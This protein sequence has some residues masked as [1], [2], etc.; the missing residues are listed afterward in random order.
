M[1]TKTYTTIDRKAQ[2][3]PSGEW[4]G[5]PDKVQWQDEATG[6]PCL[7]VRHPTSGH[8][9]GYA[10]VSPDHPLYGKGYDDV[11]FDVHGGITFT[12]PCQPG[13]D[14]SKGVC[15]LPD[16]GEPDHVWWFGFDCAH[17]GDYSP[18]DKRYEE[19][20]GYPF[21]VQ[22]YENYRTLEYVKQECANLAAQLAESRETVH[23]KAADRCAIGHQDSHE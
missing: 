15:H 1:Q 10:G 18:K 17:A 8:W 13:D 22:P 9:C 16:P 21:T 4:D 6:M 23:C 19:E 14:E 11:G 12:D 5:E 7:A 20:R 2:G 3:W